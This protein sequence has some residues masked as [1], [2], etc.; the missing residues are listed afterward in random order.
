MGRYLPSVS[1]GNDRRRWVNAADHLGRLESKGYAERSVQCYSSLHTWTKSFKVAM[2]R[3]GCP[4]RE[5]VV[6]APLKKK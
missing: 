2:A 6:A 3:S 5:A 4:S 1:I